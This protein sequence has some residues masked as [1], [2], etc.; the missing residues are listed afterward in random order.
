[1]RTI[2]LRSGEQILV[3]LTPALLKIFKK[4]QKVRS[5]GYSPPTLPHIFCFP[6]THLTN[7]IFDGAR[8]DLTKSLSMS[9]LYQV[10]HSFA[11]GSQSAPPSYNFGAIFGSTKVFMQGGVD[12]DGNVSGRFNYGWTTSTVTKL[13][14]Q[15]RFVYYVAIIIITI[16]IITIYSALVTSWPQY[17]T[18]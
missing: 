10:T 14:A 1:M 18:T 15:V 8:A 9:P 13:Q 5:S 12:H 2:A 3:F 17:D 6:A 4:K 11:L 16:I 7:F